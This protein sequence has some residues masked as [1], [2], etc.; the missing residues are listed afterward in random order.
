MYISEIR[1]KQYRH[2]SNV[3]IAPPIHSENSSAVVLAGPNGSGKSTLLELVA[4]ATS[5]SFGYSYVGSMPLG[6]D[7]FEV[8][9]E[10]TRGESEMI[11]DYLNN[12]NSMGA[13]AEEVHALAG[14]RKFTRRFS[15]SQ[16]WTSTQSMEERLFQLV[17]A[18]LRQGYGRPVGFAVRADRSYA[19]FAFPPS[20]LLQSMDK[21]SRLVNAAFQDPIN[22]FNDLVTYLI[23]EQYHYIHAIGSRHLRARNGEEV[24]E[25]PPDPIAEYNLALD[26]LLPGYQ[27]VTKASERTPTNLFVRLPNGPEIEISN[28]SSG[29]KEAFFILAN[30]IRHN[31]NDAVIAIDEPELH[32][33]PELA[34]RLVS[35]LLTTGR[36]NQIWFSTHNSEV[37]EQLGRDRT[38]FIDRTP[39][40]ATTLITPATTIGEGE[41]LLREFF[42]YSGYI[43]VGKSL[44]FLEGEHSS[45]DRST[46]TR[47]LGEHASKVKII[48][49][50]SV[51]SVT[52]VNSAVLK[53][54]ESGIGHLS[55][56]AIRDRDF[57]TQVEVDAYNSSKSE[58]LRVLQRCHIE[59][60]LLQ[61]EAIAY[62]VNL[63]LG[64]ELTANDVVDSLNKVAQ[65]ISGEVLSAMIKS[66]LQGLTQSEDFGGGSNFRGVS[67]AG[68]NDNDARSMLAAIQEQFSKTSL[69][70]IQRINDRLSDKNVK[71]IINECTNVV[72]GALTS[73]GH[74]T[75]S[76]QY[77][78]PGKR[79]L[80][81]Y[82][83]AVGLKQ[84]VLQ[85]LVID[86]LSQKRE[87]IALDLRTLLSAVVQAQD[88]PHP[89]PQPM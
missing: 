46:F 77:I 88:F 66:R 41:R 19:N 81:V 54:I 7:S 16:N 68:N 86:R 55:F 51:S 37:F 12:H 5:T 43:G 17:Q 71:N 15:A 89:T 3:S 32:L 65:K 42:G 70:V 47:L 50:G 62:V 80:E 11:Q 44:I 85:N 84:A 4:Y 28:L 39:D 23:E 40:R 53:I 26:G 38:F 9:Y 29:E 57:L 75:N 34:R 10:I 33:H 20:N 27:I 69:Q 64:L 25:E 35:T 67:L 22:Q 30:F 6:S 49:S 78:F 45:V 60:Y 14:T 52:R 13:T 76:W 18:T 1:I 73:A 2:I 56:Y 58:R 31:V 63:T 61:E 82:S 36:G 83:A 24:A 48:P 72:Q 87:L 59:N 8:D 21:A 74:D 79:M